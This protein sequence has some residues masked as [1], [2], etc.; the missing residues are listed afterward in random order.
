MLMWGAALI[1]LRKGGKILKAAEN[2]Q[3]IAAFGR[4]EYAGQNKTPHR[5]G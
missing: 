2:L 1:K 5:V 3:G 4:S